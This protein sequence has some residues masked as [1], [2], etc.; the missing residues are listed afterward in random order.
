[1]SLG[2]ALIIGPAETTQ[3]DA[4]ARVRVVLLN[5]DAVAAPPF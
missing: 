4:G 2:D 1:L 3:L 5:G